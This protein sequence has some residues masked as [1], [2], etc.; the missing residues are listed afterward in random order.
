M[1][2]TIHGVPESVPRERL[3]ALLRELG[4]EP[5]EMAGMQLHT[6][7]VTVEVFADH[8]PERRAANGARAYRY[9]MDRET[10]AVHQICVPF[11]DDPAPDEEA[12]NT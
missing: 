3:L 11:R 12:S 8:Q 9:T 10:V 6:D 2:V 5:N 7:G 1:A 4:F